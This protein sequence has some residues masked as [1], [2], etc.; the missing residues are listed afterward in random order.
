MIGDVTSHGF[1]A[2]LIMA[3][4][5]AASGIH[6]ESADSPSEAMER[7]EESLKD[8]LARTEMFLTLFYG[9]LDPSVGRLTYAN[10]GHPHAF[11]VRGATGSI[12]RL[13]ATRTP[14]GLGGPR[15][16]GDRQETWQRRQ[17]VL[18]L[19]TDG[20]TDATDDAGRRFGEERVL[21]HVQALRNKPAQ[22][23]L[24]AIFADLAAFTGGAPSADDRTL[25][26]AR[27]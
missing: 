3:L 14:L 4:A 12:I 19:F 6:G 21:G 23:A 27:V 11:L 1:G 17:D 26:I 10:A 5:M 13:E 22:Q 7:L 2:A 24:E 8:E 16:P 18:C 15:E 25:L 20:I 9:V